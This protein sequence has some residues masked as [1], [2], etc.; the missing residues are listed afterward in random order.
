M[1][2]LPATIVCFALY[3]VGFRFYA[4]FLAERIYRLD[5]DVTTPAHAQRDGIDYVPTNRFVLFGHH[6][7]SITGLAPMLGPAVAVIWGWLPAMLWV[8]LG[9]VLVGCVHDFSALVVSMRARGQSI[10][11][12]AEGV[13][14]HRAKALFL[15]LIFFGVALA[16]PDPHGFV[17]GRGGHTVSVRTE[18]HGRVVI[19]PGGNPV[20]YERLA[21][22]T[23]G[24]DPD[25]SVGRSEH[26][27]TV[28]AEAKLLD[29]ALQS[30][31]RHRWLRS[32]HTPQPHDAIRFSR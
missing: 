11:K 8:V 26:P 27:P 32:V 14:G 21:G 5:A 23:H 17:L 10:G 7:A 22:S 20:Q 2:P 25:C 12:V 18:R 16:T 4:K 6:Y 28:G 31:E 19:A 9:A 13:I 15:A 1:G 3:F 24:P 29:P 30:P